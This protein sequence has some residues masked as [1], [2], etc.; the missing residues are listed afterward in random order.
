MKHNSKGILLGG[1]MFMWSATLPAVAQQQKDLTLQEAV[2]LS[3]KA[4]PELKGSQA[5]ID[6]ATAAIRE[7]LDRKLPDA[8]LTGSYLRVNNPNVSL[9]IKTSGSGGS[10]GGSTEEQTKV[11]Q[12]MYAMGNVSLPIYA[13]G[14]IRY[15]VESSRLLA[16]ATK[17]DADANREEVVL[18]T[19]EAFNNLYKAKAAVALVKENL[20]DAQQRVKDFNRQEQNGLLARND[21]LK[22]ELQASNIELTLL[23]AENNWKLANINMNLLLGLPDSTELNPLAE[24]FQ[25]AGAL[26]PMENYIQQAFSA[27]KD[28]QALEVRSKAAATGVKAAKAEMLPSVAVTG[29]YVDLHVPGLMTVTNAVNVGLGVQYDIGSLWKN[30]AKVQQAEARTRELQ[31][32]QES[33]NNGIRLQVAQAY[34]NYLSS[35]KKQ[36]VYAKAV[37]QAEENYKVVNNKYNNG[38]ATTTDLLDADVARLQARLNSAFAQSDAVVAYNRLLQAAGILET[39]K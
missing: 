8:S 16:E 5:K 14:R 27:R 37:A 20:Q 32:G 1:L 36:E 34:Q 39:S 11:S 9:K 25:E 12:A 13:G 28:L 15:G 19:I 6:A 4:S 17:L 18:N 21:L 26:K 24:S 7:A 3:I 38:L 23:D 30:K 31:A 33:L 2:A 29:G 35:Q 22:A 10:G